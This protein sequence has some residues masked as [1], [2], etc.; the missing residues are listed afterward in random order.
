MCRSVGVVCYVVVFVVLFLLEVYGAESAV[1]LYVEAPAQIQ[2][3]AERDSGAG[4]IT[5]IDTLSP[6]DVV[7]NA[8]GGYSYKLPCHGAS[9]EPVTVFGQESYHFGFVAV[10]VDCA[11]SR[12]VDTAPFAYNEFAADVGSHGGKHQSVGFYRQLLGMQGR[13]AAQYQQK[14][15]TAWKKCMVMGFRHIGVY[16]L[17]Y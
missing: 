14:E 5:L 3:V 10:D 2:R 9:V 11:E 4:G 12:D 17:G 7:G 1:K 15:D 6:C 8:E 16:R 13:S